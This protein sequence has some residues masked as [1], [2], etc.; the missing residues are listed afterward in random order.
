MGHDRVADLIGKKRTLEILEL[1]AS[2]S[3]LNYSEIEA[4]VATSSDIVTDRLELLVDYG[5]IDRE[6]RSARDVR[7]TISE[8][9]EEFLD[10]LD[11]LD[12]FLAN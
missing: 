5:L 11:D 12:S 3:P 7:Y 4:N 9:G 1:V 8:K 6:E 10:H 2:E